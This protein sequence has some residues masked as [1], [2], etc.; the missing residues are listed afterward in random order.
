MERVKEMEQLGKRRRRRKRR[1]DVG[2]KHKNTDYV[3]LFDIKCVQVL[4]LQ[5]KDLGVQFVFVG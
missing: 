4:F 3:R 5:L 2:I 1:K